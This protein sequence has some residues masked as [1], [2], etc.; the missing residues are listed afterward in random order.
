MIARIKK[1]PKAERRV[2]FKREYLDSLC[3]R[4]LD[5]GDDYRGVQLLR[6]VKHVLFE[7]SLWLFVIFE[8]SER[9]KVLRIS[10]KKLLRYYFPDSLEPAQFSEGWR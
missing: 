4:R 8:S 10:I 1:M 3:K 2:V 9:F 7:G 5:M 6:G